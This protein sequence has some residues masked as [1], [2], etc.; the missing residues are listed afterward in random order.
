[1]KKY[2]L[3]LIIILCLA[4]TLAGYGADLYGTYDQRIKLTIDQT[5]ID[6]ANLTWFPVTVHLTSTA[7]EEVFAEFDADA[8]YLKV[9]F[10]KA[11][12]VTE[13]KA[14]CELFDDSG[15]V[16][17]YHVS[18]D[19]WV[20]THDA[21]TD[22]YMY[23]DNDAADN[24]DFI[25]AINT[26]AGAA[27]WDGDSEGV[28]HLTGLLD[29][30]SNNNDLTNDG[31]IEVDGKVGKARD[32]EADSSQKAYITDAAQTGLDIAGTAM[33]IE[34]IIK[35]ESVGVNHCLVS[36][37]G[38]STNGINYLL[39]INTS[40]NPTFYFYNSGWYYFTDTSITFSADTWYYLAVTYDGSHIR[41][42]L[43]EDA[44]G[45]SEETASMLANARNFAL[46]YQVDGTQYLDGIQDETKVLQTPRNAAWLKATYNSL[47]DS[48]LTYGSEETPS[49]ITWNGIVITKWNGITITTP[50]NTQ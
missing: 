35:L 1:M 50:L 49:G 15:Q 28:W 40:N 36:K 39:D 25:G 16:A 7:G 3:P 47:W 33:T 27:V 44:K 41:F 48:L 37:G 8:D 42:Y 43:N 6:T 38:T 20:I 29:S 24:T 19:G 2:L 14:E 4:F 21:D 45:S 18:L 26:A 10:T 30:T 13:L 11:D 34:T 17:I 46:G 23:Y 12:G 22:F 31:T 9:A 32:F 5:K